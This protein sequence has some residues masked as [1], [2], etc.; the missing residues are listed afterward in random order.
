MLCSCA[1]TVHLDTPEPLK[2]DIEMKIDV[3]QR[4]VRTQVQRQM[5]GEES[6]ALRNRDARSSE[7]WTMK[8]DGVAIET[9]NGYM[10]VKM[11]SGW[12]AAYVNRL[13]TE[14]NRDRHILYNAEATDSARPISVIEEEA[15]RRL[16]Q[17]AYGRPSINTIDSV[18]APVEKK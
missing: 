8:N 6:K 9:K 11:K 13:V 16:R 17:Q 12:D 5:S 7:I 4:D 2:V 10:E 3:Y 1:P 15:G 18:V 14:E